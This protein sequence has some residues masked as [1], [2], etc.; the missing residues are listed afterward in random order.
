[1]PST[2]T[3]GITVDVHGH[4]TINKEYR[5]ERIFL[6]LGLLAQED[7]EHL[8]LAEID[9]LELAIERRKH[10]RPLFS[11]CAKRFLL[12]SKNKRS[13]TAIAWHVRLLLRSVGALEVQRVHDDTLRPFVE[14]TRR[15]RQRN[16]GQPNS[17]SRPRGLASGCTGLSRRRGPSAA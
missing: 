14:A 7:A 12:E 16:H 6:R 15:G 2:R 4:R 10:A 5:G 8:L 9:R 1:M 3:R 13:A 17:R 11:D